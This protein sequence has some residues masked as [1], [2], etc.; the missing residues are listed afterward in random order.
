M[1][2]FTSKIKLFLTNFPPR[3]SNTWTELTTMP[4]PRKYV[5]AG[6][7][8]YSDGSE[9]I[10]VTGGCCYTELTEIFNLQTF[11]WSVGEDLPVAIGYGASVP[12]EDSFLI[13][14]G[15]PDYLDSIYYFYPVRQ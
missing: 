13:V 1:V 14:G 9:H 4:S 3:T 2:G 10:V 15:Y 7:V 11:T 5:Q 12:F 8:Q 6:L